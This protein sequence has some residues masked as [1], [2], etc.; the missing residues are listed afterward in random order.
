MK[1][2]LTGHELIERAQVLGVSIYREDEV[3]PIG[4]K[5]IMAAIAA[6][7]II[8]SRV[9]EAERHIREHKLW[10]IAL[11]SSISALVSALAAWAAIIYK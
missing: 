10:L 9:L 2:L 3:I 1:K 4:T 8:Q 11:I 7:S 5:P 6:E